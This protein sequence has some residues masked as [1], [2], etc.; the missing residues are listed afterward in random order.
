MNQEVPQPTTATRSP[1]R[2][3]AA[4]EVSTSAAARRQQAGWVAS[5]SAVSELSVLEPSVAV[6]PV[7]VRF[8][9]S[10]LRETD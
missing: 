4:A 3:R 5:S 10:R 9:L 6:M 2:G 1:T 8:S 7:M